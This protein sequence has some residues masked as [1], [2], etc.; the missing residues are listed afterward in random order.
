MP[1]HGTQ[2]GTRKKHPLCVGILTIPSPDGSSHIMKSYVDWFEHR[3]IRVLPVPFDTTEYKTYFHR[4]NG[5]FIP[6]TDRGYD[7]QNDVLLRTIRALYTLSRKEWFPIWGSCFGMELLL[8]LFGGQRSSH[9][10][11][12]R[13]A[14]QWTGPSRMMDS[15]PDSALLE[16]SRSTVHHHDYGISVEDMKGPLQR[17]YTVV[18][19]AVDDSGNEYVAAIEAKRYPIYAVQFHPERLPATAPFLAF[20]VSELRK[21]SHRC[22]I[23]PPVERIARKCSHYDGW[24]N[25]LCYFFT[26]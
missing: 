13:Y 6:G 17:F 1:R 3:G 18:A 4:I 20:F 2:H 10:A 14:L 8:S 16:Q 12:G 21:S 24:K 23:V 7:T 19:T 9:P 22:D 26:I 25:Q 5:L 11:Q 15:F